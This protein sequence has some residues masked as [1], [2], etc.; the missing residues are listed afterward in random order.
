MKAYS[1]IV[2][3]ICCIYKYTSV[4]I[5]PEPKKKY[6]KILDMELILNM[7]ECYLTLSIDFMWLRNLFYQPSK[8]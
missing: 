1:L 6:F 5:M 7:R 2:I 8:T 4:D 3:F